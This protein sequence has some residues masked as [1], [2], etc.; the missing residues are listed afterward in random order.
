MT[1]LVA[2]RSAGIGWLVPVFVGLVA[3]GVQPLQPS[4]EKQPMGIGGSGGSP[5]TS[6]FA[7][8]PGTIGDQGGTVGDDGGAPI[9]LGPYAP[10]SCLAISPDPAL[11]RL[12][13]G[14]VGDWT[15]DATTPAGWTWSKA[16]VEFRFFCDGHYQDRCLAA[17][18]LAPDSCVALYYGT[19]AD[20]PAKTY[21]V[22]D[23][24]TALIVIYFPV[25]T[26]T[27]DQLA[28]INLSA[29]GSALSYDLYHEDQ[30]GP[31]HYQLIR[32][33]P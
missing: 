25:T 28:N 32:P 10:A 17:E 4:Q 14:I 16:N 18:G 22:Q 33:L 3:C 21:Q 11:A 23:A 31:V 24:S 1:Y 2:A 27:D 6:G 5:D 8:Q 12:Q 20:N 30:Y 19:D 15:G 29:D 9:S 13:T 7:G 26:T